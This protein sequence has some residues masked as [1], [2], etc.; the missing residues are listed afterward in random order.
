M[1]TC[2]SVL[3]LLMTSLHV[4]K[5][6]EPCAS[7]QI[8]E[9]LAQENP[10]GAAAIKQWQEEAYSHARQNG[11][12]KTAPL[13]QIP[14]VVHVVYTTAEENI[15]DSLIYQQ[16]EVLNQDFRRLNPDTSLTRN[17]FKPVAGD[18]GIEFF[19]A[20]LDPDGNPTTGITR[21]QGNPGGFLG[22]FDPFSDNVK[23]NADGG[24]DAW[25]TDK[26]L[27][28]WVCNILGGFG[29]LGYAYPP[30]GDVANWPA[31]TA[32]ADTTLQG[33]VVHFPVFGPRNPLAAANG[34]DMVN[35]GR[36][37][38]HEVGH[39]LGLRHI[40]GDGDCTEDDG[41]NDTPPAS[42]NANQV[43]DFTKNSC[44]DQGGTDFPDQIENFM[45]YAA[46][47]CMNMF[48]QEQVAA[49][50]YVLDNFRNPLVESGNNLTQNSIQAPNT[51]M[52][53]YP[54][55]AKDMV[56]IQWSGKAALGGHLALLDARG[57]LVK[58]L[59]IP[60]S[61]SYSMNI[62]SLPAGWYILRL[63]NEQGAFFQKLLVR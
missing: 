29:V 46:D 44:Q 59:E 26:Y 32:P 41:L 40:W 47:S 18:A 39:Y 38:T 57:A 62:Q 13:Y 61:S 20:T 8:L 56:H 30:V 27:N 5:A 4:L 53:L 33:V 16:I 17:E 52:Q 9:H 21:T 58:K 35:R 6:Q 3:I 10:T 15:P 14:V 23:K 45:D 54:N 22:L 12:N 25:P 19:L 49:M 63:N 48:T 43:C 36:T 7:H 50:Q 31:G 1:K 42:D 55:P 2:F 37:L 51:G 34:L 28:I 24:K 11:P 60:A